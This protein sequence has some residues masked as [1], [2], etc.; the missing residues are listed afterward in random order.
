[1][2]LTTLRNY[3]SGILHNV[4]QLGLF[5]GL[6]KT[7]FELQVRGKK[8]VRDSI[9]FKFLISRLHTITITIDLNELAEVLSG[10]ANV[11]LL[12]LH[13]PH[14]TLFK[15]SHYMHSHSR[16]ED[17]YSTSLREEYLHILFGIFQYGRF[18]Y[19]HSFIRSFIL[20]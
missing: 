8:D 18:V 1:M 11:K 20:M 14:C 13:F 4:S 2:T 6:L 19:S 17:L 5:V 9:I 7:R 3:W 15:Q 10:F 12:F 16:G